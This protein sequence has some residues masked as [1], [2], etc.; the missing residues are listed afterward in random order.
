MPTTPRP[1]ADRPP[2]DPPHPCVARVRRHVERLPKDSDPRALTEIVPREAAGRLSASLE[3]TAHCDQ[4]RVRLVRTLHERPGR[5]ETA[6]V[7]PS[8]PNRRAPGS[9]HGCPAARGDVHSG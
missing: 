5:L 1:R 4:N 7:T 2:T 3:G 9:D 6:P 8:R